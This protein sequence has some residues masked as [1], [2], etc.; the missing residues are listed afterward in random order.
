[1][2]YF[3]KYVY[4]LNKIKLINLIIE[5]FNLNLLKYNFNK[6]KNKLK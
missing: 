1:M 2:F 5:L 3:Q 4:D 6:Y